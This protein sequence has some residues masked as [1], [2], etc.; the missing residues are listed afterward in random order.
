MY[1]LCLV[2]QTLRGPKGPSQLILLVFLWSSDPFWGP[3]ILLSIL[4]W[5][6]NLHPLFGCGWLC[7]SELAS[8]WNL[9]KDNMFLKTHGMGLKLGQLLV[10]HSLGLCSIFVPSFLI[11]RTNFV[12][13]FVG[14]LVYLSFHWAVLPLPALPNSPAPSAT[15]TYL[16]IL[17][18]RSLENIE[19][20]WW[21]L[22]FKLKEANDFIILIQQL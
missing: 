22:Y 14:G 16:V 2:A 6:Y 11:D 9:S 13:S 10:G 12:E 17:S 4:P 18:P 7:L 5:V 19:S 8:L 20:A 3:A 15:G 21:K 1:V